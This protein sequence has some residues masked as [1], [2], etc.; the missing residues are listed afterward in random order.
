MVAIFTGLGAGLGQGSGSV[1]GAAGLLG[2]SGLG[3]GGEQ[4]FLN[5]ATGNLVINKTDEFLIG[6]G[7]DAGIS[8]TYNSLGDLSDE[9]GDNWRQSTDRRVFGLTGTAN[10]VG[11]TVKRVSGDGSIATYDFNSSIGVYVSTAGGGAYDRLGYSGGLWTWTEGASQITEKYAAYGTNSWRITEQGDTDGNKLT[12]TYTGANLTEVKTAD[13]SYIRYLWSGSN[14]TQITTGYTDLQSGVDRTRTSTR[15]AYDGLNRLSKVTVDLSPQDGLIADGRTYTTAYTYDG[16]SKRV[17]L[18]SQSDG[19][20]IEFGYTAFSTSTVEYRITSI[21]QWVDDTTTRTTLIDYDVANGITTVKDPLGNAAKLVYAGG[22]LVQVVQPAPTPGAPQIIS[23]FTYNSRGDVEVVRRFDGFANLASNTAASETTFAYDGRGNAI[24]EVDSLGNTI[25]RTYGSKNELLTETRTGSDAASTTASHTTRYAY[26]SENHLRYLVSAEGYITEFRYTAAGQLEYTIEYPEH[27]YDVSGLAASTA[28]TELQLDAARDGIANRSSTKIT[29]NTYDARGNITATTRYGIANQWGGVSPAEGTSST[30]YVY[31]QAG[32]LLSRIEQG[33]LAETFV[34][35]G[36]GRVI[37]ATAPGG[38]TTLSIY[39]DGVNKVDTVTI[40]AGGNLVDQLG[41]PS[42]GDGAAGANL[43]D[44]SGWAGEKKGDNLVNLGGWPADADNLPS[45]AT[46]VPG[47]LSN[48]YSAETQWAKAVGPEGQQTAVIQ[49]GQIGGSE[50]GGGHLTNSFTIDP[51]KAYEFTIYFQWTNDSAHRTYFGLNTNVPATVKNAWDG[52]ENANPYFAHPAPGEGLQ[53]G[54]W[55]KMVGYVLPQGSANV[56]PGDLGGIYDVGTGAKAGDVM[57]YRWSENRS[58]NQAYARFFNYYGQDRQGVYTNFYKPEVRQV[59]LANGAASVEG[60][61]ND[62]GFAEETRWT[63]TMGPDGTNVWA[64]QAGQTDTDE[65]GGGNVS[66]DFTING[67]KTYQFTYYFKKSSL[68]SAHSLYFGLSPDWNGTGFVKNANDGASNT[69]PYF[70]ACDAPW[71]QTN[72]VE[73]RWYKVVGYVFAEGSKPV[74]AGAAGGVYDT[75]SG[76]KIYDVQNFTWKEDRPSDQVHTRFFDYYYQSQQGYSTDFYKPEVR[77]FDTV[78]ATPGGYADVPGW[79]NSWNVNETSWERVTGPDGRQVVAMK[80]GQTDSTEKGGGNYTNEAP[81]DPTKNYEFSLYFRLTALNKHTIFFGLSA[82]DPAY[83]VNSESGAENGNPYFAGIMPGAGF[84]VGRWYKIVGFVLAAGSTASWGSLGGVYDVETG[85]KVSAVN[86]FAWKP[87]LPGKTVHARFFNFYDQA[88]QGQFT[89]FY[90]AS[91]REVGDP[92]RP[93]LE[94]AS[95][96]QSSVFNRAGELINSTELAALATVGTSK[97]KYDRLGRLRMATDASNRNSYYLYDKM[98]RKVADI[99]HDG[100]VVEYR[101]NGQ[102]L[103]AATARYTT[104]LTAA[105]LTALGNASLEVELSSIRPANHSY[106]IWEWTVYDKNGRVIET[107][108]GDGS[109]TTFAYDQSNRLIR[110]LAYASKLTGTQIGNF[111][112]AGP[113]SPV[114][115]TANSDKDSISRNFYDKDGRLI[116]VL[117]GEGYL[118]QI[119]YDMA[120]QKVQEI[121]Y[122]KQTNVDR[123]AS[124]FNALKTNVAGGFGD[125]VTRYVYDGQGLLRY[126]VDGLNQVT[127][128]DYNQARQVK[129]TTVFAGSLAAT[130]DYTF[131]N[132]K[133]MVIQANL[134]ANEATRSS[135]SIYDAAGRVAFAVDA[136]RG[137]TGFNYNSA[138]QV[139]KSVQYAAL[140][141]LGWEPTL[142][143]MSAWAAGQATNVDNRV[144]R[145]YYNGRGELRFTVDAEGYLT[146]KEY[147]A[148]GRLTRTTS[149]DNA[150]AVDDSTT[151]SKVLSLSGGTAMGSANATNYVY[152]NAGRLS[153]VYDGANVRRYLV[154][155]ANGTLQSDYAAYGHATDQSRTLYVYDGVGRV[156]EEHRA[157]GTVDVVVTRFVYDGL[158]NVITVTDPEQNQTNRTYDKVGRLKTETNALGHITRYDYSAFGDV[159][160]VTDARGNTTTNYYDKLGRVYLTRDAEAYVTETLYSRFGDVERVIRYYNRTTLNPDGS[161]NLRPAAHAKDA[162]TNFAYDRL[163]RVERV[164]DAE[165]HYEEYGLDAFGNATTVRNKRGGVTIK[166]YDRR[167]LLVAETLPMS[168]TNLDG[169]TQASSV[170]NRF[171]YDARGNRT[172]MYEAFGLTEQRVTSYL[173]DKAD[174]LKETRHNPVQVVSQV[175]HKTLSTVTPTELVKYDARGNVIEKVDA[176]NARTLYY[177]NRLNEK[178]VEIDALGGYSEYTYDNNGNLK[179]QR[180]YGAVLEMLPVSPGGTPPTPPPGDYRQTAFTYDK[181]NRLETSTVADVRV[182]AWDGNSYAVTVRPLTT[183]YKYDAGGNVTKLTDANGGVIYSYY[184]GLGRKTYQI[185]QEK[186]STAWNYDAEGNVLTERRYATQFTGTP[187]EWAIPYIPAH[188][189]DRVTEFTYDKN[190]RRR[191]EQR[192]GVVAWNVNSTTGALTAAASTV[193][194]EYQYNGL[195]QVTRK[196]ESTGDFVEYVYDETGR[197]T[198]EYR[199]AY[200][201]QDDVLVRPM[202]GYYYNGV[203]NLVLTKQS[204]EAAGYAERR[205]LY[206]YDGGRLQASVDA[207]GGTRRYYYD[208]AGNLLREDYDRQKQNYNSVLEGVLYVRDAL[209]RVREQS[210][211]AWASTGGWVKGDRQNIAYNGYG[212]IS[213]R[214]LNGL[215]Q[216]QFE[217]DKAGRLVKTNSGDGVWRYFLNDGN[218]NQTL[219]IESVGR[220]LTGKSIE[221]VLG[222]ATDGNST[223]IGGRFIDG[224]NSTIAVFDKRN[225]ATATILAKRQL[226][227]TGAATDL[228][229]NRGYN[230]FGDLAWERDARNNQTTY[231]YN[232][233]GRRISVERPTVTV[234]SENGTRQDMKPTDRLYYDVSGRLVATRD[235][236]NNLTTRSLVQG[237]GYGQTE[238]LVAKEFHAD[239]GIARRGY[240]AFGDMRRSWDE[241]DRRADMTYDKLGRLTQVS[242]PSFNGE[243]SGR[244]TDNYRYDI[245]GQRIEHWNSVL[246][247]GNLEITDYDLQGRVTRQVA[248]GGDETLTSYSWN[249][250]LEERGMGAASGWEQLTTF[251][252][253]KT[254]T[255]VKDYT[256]REYYR[257]DLGGHDISTYYDYGGR[258]VRKTISGGETINY[259]NLNTGWVGT[260]WKGTGVAGDGQIYDHTKTVYQY[261]ET[262]NR[263]SEVYKNEGG[264]WVEVPVPP[265]PSPPPSSPPP[266]PPP[267]GREPPILMESVVEPEFS[268]EAIDGSEPTKWEYRTYQQTFQSMSAAYDALGR[269][270]AWNEAGT[271]TMPAAN[272]QYDYDANGNVRRTYTTSKAIDAFGRAA[273][274]TTK[275]YWYRYDSMNRVLTSRGAVSAAGT[276]WRSS[277]GVDIAYDLAGQRRFVTSSRLNASGQLYDQREEYRYDDAGNLR[278]VY[279]A[280]NT[281]VNSNFGASQLKATYYYDGMNRLRQ[282]SEWV[283]DGTNTGYLSA[284]FSRGLSYNAKGQIETDSVTTRRD[285]GTFISITK[286]TFGT[287][288]DYALGAVVTATTENIVGLEKKSE[289]FTSTV[290]EWRDGAVQRTVSHTPDKSKP[291]TVHTTQ[292]GYNGWGHLESANIIDGRSR[293]VTFTN[294]M[295]GQVILRKEAD[296]DT[297][298]GDP[299]EFWYRFVGKEIGYTGNNGTLETDYN[300]S[301]ANRVREPDD[302]PFRFGLDTGSS[303]SDFDQSYDAI[304]SYGQGGLGGSYTVRQGDTLSSIAAGLWGDAAL[305]YK[306]AEA[307]GMTA[308]N[309]LAEGQRLN[310]PSGVMSSR[311]NADTFKPYDPGAAVGDTSPTVP[312]DDQG[313]CGDFGRYLMI[314]VAA[315]VTVAT[316]GAASQLLGSA[317]LGGAAAG[318]LGSVASQGFGLMTGIQTEPFSFKEVGLSAVTGGIS[319]GISSGMGGIR[320]TGNPILAGA[321][322]GAFSSFASQGVAMAIGIQKKFDWAG[323]AAGA[324]GGAAAGAGAGR[325]VTSSASAITS[326]AAQSLYNGQSFGDNLLAAL[327]DVVGSTAGNLVAD[328]LARHSVAASAPYEASAGP[329]GA[330]PDGVG[331]ETP[332][333]AWTGPEAAPITGPLTQ[334]QTDRLERIRDRDA[335][336]I[337]RLLERADASQRFGLFAEQHLLDAMSLPIERSQPAVRELRVRYGALAG[338][339]VVSLDGVGDPEWVFRE[340]RTLS[341]P[342]LELVRNERVRFKV[343]GNS[344]ADA[345]LRGRPRGWDKTKSW[346]DV[347][348]VFQPESRS[349]IAAT[350]GVL[351]TGSTRTFYHELGHALDIVTGSRSNAKSFRLAHTADAPSFYHTEPQTV[352]GQPVMLN[353]QPVIVQSEFEKYFTQVG[354]PAGYI[355]ESYAES[356]A[357]HLNQ[358]NITRGNWKYL[359]PNVYNAV[360]PSIFVHKSGPTRFL[361]IIV[362]RAASLIGK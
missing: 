53:V 308:A 279:Y 16:T 90:D 87:N 50:A 191:F 146:R 207:E 289:S 265:P 205:T 258:A 147:D 39:R 118:S 166:D 110:T 284:N 157:Y 228:S 56:A 160:C 253:G 313:R 254:A 105:Q 18:I 57:N 353:G 206:T 359:H 101:Y 95:Y 272:V 150:V 202:M 193:Q 108:E 31:D 328:R 285:A 155:N 246:G 243:V 122:E 343:V 9:N 273:E 173:Y 250:S 68:A 295:N 113:T 259:I 342:M 97:Y 25:T 239:G 49:A 46:Q 17:A 351:T 201:D 224:I 32:R 309:A 189:D 35:D 287:G 80:A 175:D 209:G 306:L 249:S 332:P 84:Q 204:A 312:K 28:V 41:W 74:A 238:A 347:A 37:A 135:W 47:W 124:T 128:Y 139:I 98:G 70:F 66:N 129:R 326:A 223:V 296:G 318:A 4:V 61:Q 136:E 178:V 52:A 344:M 34:Y 121:A 212:E 58:E 256:G 200:L 257:K 190:G 88:K 321:A 162:A 12:F 102:G 294:D 154:Y 131:D 208:A 242:R 81:V 182:G 293:Q 226:N 323:V 148:E 303:Y 281:S 320:A 44:T 172:K 192:S 51:N 230:A 264:Y 153:S 2:S 29:Y 85:A 236:N 114:L 137:V 78:A 196:I 96:V 187:L 227:Q 269:L 55:Y 348:A 355:S 240:D 345:G 119:V 77:E 234:T 40:P 304:N 11:S 316:Q 214:G 42:A 197:L 299:F 305:W 8:R 91:I 338:I 225:Q 140:P 20:K 21:K 123:A 92:S 138:G 19:S 203:S 283:A 159:T 125:R 324:A 292:Y 362:G 116:G 261:D 99:D 54:R 297:S 1:L 232:T 6:R 194:I 127:Q 134:E 216:E 145:H 337:R 358:A 280:Q 63:R 334:E 360:D 165:G 174:R 26:D 288:S 291:G 144:T 86:N 255:L 36:M 319:G 14:I 143:S 217:Y 186:Y 111:K 62:S 168:S 252:N 329:S 198:T 301:I 221:E 268:I 188:A 142:G 103:L 170:T 27:F 222:I 215:W 149:W 244:L 30:Y 356:F 315:A 199:S 83:V 24:S 211:A 322:R 156:K 104:R 278:S 231:T 179:T 43:V 82:G 311:Y 15:Y 251:A 183:T 167:G 263:L 93:A 286:N 218:G 126:Q 5:G 94:S 38:A 76:T 335:A 307:N 262:G 245:L 72:L 117:D 361:S 89:Y 133:A 184:D 185:D 235:A 115:P 22:N 352:A 177:Y 132:I 171:E 100:S 266:P 3:R 302:G 10:T 310:I 354:N 213:Q 298:K 163:G 112:N 7:P 13:L 330:Q 73:N 59:N 65:P 276:I 248:F 314:A 260:M 267:V 75:V 180:T 331:A 106:D 60:W 290:Y 275:E 33:Q 195:G 277:A 300:T 64:I 220:D 270:T 109:V 349:V 241:L 176:N 274:T 271:P 336:R 158:G 325:F 247:S 151:I 341:T 327:P 317:I 219:S 237:T 23:K 130:S 350:N 340:L 229:V 71:Q 141:T 282:Q 357:H 45:G 48:P 120:G 79:L 161:W 67:S 233:M 181:I 107:I 169:T 69:N 339:R 333:G 164:T 210:V 346:A 152:D